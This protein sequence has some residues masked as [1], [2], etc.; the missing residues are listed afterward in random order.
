MSENNQHRV[1]HY[2]EDWIPIKNQWAQI[3]KPK[4]VFGRSTPQGEILTRLAKKEFSPEE[5]A[6]V[7][8]ILGV[9]QL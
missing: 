9:T 4:V 8:G 5:Y 6:I 1:S 7:L 2:G 3:D